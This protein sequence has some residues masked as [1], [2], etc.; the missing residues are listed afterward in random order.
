MQHRHFHPFV[1]P[2]TRW[3]SKSP[4]SSFN[5]ALTNSCCLIIIR[6]FKVNNKGIQLFHLQ[7]VRLQLGS[8]RLRLIC[9]FAYD[10]YV[11]AL[12]LNYCSLQPKKKTIHSI[13]IVQKN[14]ALKHVSQNVF[15]NFIEGEPGRLRIE[16]VNDIFLNMIKETCDCQTEN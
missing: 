7:S 13:L 3:P 2:N 1:R 16:C 4:C 5:E 14:N 12:N 9:Q 10:S 6:A 15:K 11:E 8:V